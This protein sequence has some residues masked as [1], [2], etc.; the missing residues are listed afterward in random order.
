[1]ARLRTL[2]PEFFTHELLAELSPLHRLLYAGLWCHADREGRLEDRPRYLKTV[3]LPYDDCDVDRMLADLQRQ[4][5]VVRYVANGRHCIHIPAFLRHQ[6]PHQKEKDSELPPPPVGA[7]NDGPKPEVPLQSI[8]ITHASEIPVQ[9]PDKHSA[10][11]G[12]VP[13][14]ART[15]PAVLSIGLGSCLGSGLDGAPGEV[16]LGT[17]LRVYGHYR[18][19]FNRRPPEPNAIERD[20]ITARLR[21]GYPAEDLEQAITGLSRSKHHK[22]KAFEALRYALGDRDAVERCMKWAKDPPDQGSTKGRAPESAR[23][24]DNVTVETD[25]DGQ[26]VL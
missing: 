6:N 14:K 16:V 10:S 26:V 1:M 23:N 21:E 7:S 15:I 12:L 18:K 19:T 8:A 20:V 5:F 11:T 2:K 3:I 4:G 17:V 13:E 24:W 9:A 22:V 25:E